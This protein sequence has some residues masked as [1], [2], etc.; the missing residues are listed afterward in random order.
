M[1]ILY[2]SVA[3]ST[4]GVFVTSQCLQVRA[5]LR[6]VL[7]IFL[8]WL[9]HRS[10][11]GPFPL[12]GCWQNS[13]SCSPRAEVPISWTV[14]SHRPLS[15]P[16]YPVALSTSKPITAPRILLRLRVSDFLFWDQLERTLHLAD[17]HRTYCGDRFIKHISVGS[18]CCK[19]KAN[20]I[21]CVS[22]NESN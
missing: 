17:G 2:C 12:T 20:V 9:G 11:L 10:Y 6:S 14:V 18:L 4:A 19:P 21:L 16:F 7:C 1:L 3:Q 13:F 5:R 8:G 15:D 22:Y